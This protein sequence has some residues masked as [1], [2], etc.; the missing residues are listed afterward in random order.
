MEPGLCLLQTPGSLA[1]TAPTFPCSRTGGE[2]RGGD[3]YRVNEKQIKN[4]S[5]GGERSGARGFF[6]GGRSPGAQQP[7]RAGVRS[8]LQE[9]G[10]PAG[11]WICSRNITRDEVGV[12][13][14]R[15]NVMSKSGSRLTHHRRG[16]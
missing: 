12:R 11:G 14:L 9:A 15:L 5:G 2:H 10:G 3:G 8:E 16:Y 7:P 4:V 13:N 6:G 1:R